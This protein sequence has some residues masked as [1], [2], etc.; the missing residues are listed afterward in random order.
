MAGGRDNIANGTLAVLNLAARPKI[1]PGRYA[2]RLERAMAVS[3]DA[4]K[5]PLKDAAG[6]L[7]ITRPGARPSATERG[8]Y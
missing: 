3:R 5:T 1:A 7:V 8:S 2:V 6:R 4:R